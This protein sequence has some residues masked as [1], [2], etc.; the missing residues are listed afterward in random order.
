MLN[1]LQND[2]HSGL[3]TRA[4]QALLGNALS[5]T[6]PIRIHRSKVKTQPD[7]PGHNKS[8]FLFKVACI[9]LKCFSFL[10]MG[11]VDIDIYRTQKP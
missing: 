11:W 5:R 2:Q 7:L 3:C 4:P 1:Q 6:R 10:L 8:E 9:F